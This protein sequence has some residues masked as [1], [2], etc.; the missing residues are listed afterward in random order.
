LVL[1]KYLRTLHSPA[2]IIFVSV[3]VSDFKLTEISIY[4][5]LFS[6]PRMTCRAKVCCSTV[7][8]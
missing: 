8:S 4:N 3:M 5:T 1:L 2:A 6:W 7:Q